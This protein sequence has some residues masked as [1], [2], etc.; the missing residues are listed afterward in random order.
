MEI[1][2]IAV[3]VTAQYVKQY[4]SD[5]YFDWLDLLP[6]KS[7]DII[8]QPILA[9]NWYDQTDSVIIPTQMVGRLFFETEQD[10]AWHLGRY[11]S[12]IALK[13]IYKIFLKVSSPNFVINRATSVFATYYRP[14]EIEVKESGPGKVV[15][16]LSGFDK[17]DILVMYRIGGWISNTLDLTF[18][19]DS[20]VEFDHQIVGNSLKTVIKV[21]WKNKK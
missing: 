18:S 20:K 7:K 8:S 6:Q 4:H 15:L 11:S 10:A 19:E 14:S 21:T 5:R 3:K 1:K 2:G 13:G 9:T 17:N 12:E 16:S